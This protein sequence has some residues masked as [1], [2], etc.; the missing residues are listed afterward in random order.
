MKKM[1]NAPGGLASKLA[2]LTC[3]VLPDGVGR[4]QYPSGVS[5]RG[6]VYGSAANPV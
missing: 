2:G 4:V 6:I 5:S 3:S 1:L